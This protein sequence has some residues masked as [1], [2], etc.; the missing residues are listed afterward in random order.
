MSTVTMILA[1]RSGNKPLF[2]IMLPLYLLLCCATVYIK[3]H[4]FI[5]SLVGFIFACLIYW[6]MY[7]LYELTP[8]LTLPLSRRG[9]R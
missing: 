7:K 8:S 1:Y 4:Y 9:K 2:F 6:V 5:D 3:A